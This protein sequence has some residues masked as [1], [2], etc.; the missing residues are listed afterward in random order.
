MVGVTDDDGI[1]SELY[2]NDRNFHESEIIKKLKS[3]SSQIWCLS[4]VTIHP[5]LL[6]LRILIHEVGGLQ[7]HNNTAHSQS[8]SVRRTD[9]QGSF[10][11]STYSECWN[12]LQ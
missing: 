12:L 10:S 9:D 6:G 7:Q 3:L 4:G 8:H 2:Q 5:Q 1:I 11:S